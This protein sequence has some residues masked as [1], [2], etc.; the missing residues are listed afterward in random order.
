M[1]QRALS[2]RSDAVRTCSAAIG[3]LMRGE[4]SDEADAGATV[5]AVFIRSFLVNRK[6]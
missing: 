6:G 4:D 2:T 5:L 1:A 3:A